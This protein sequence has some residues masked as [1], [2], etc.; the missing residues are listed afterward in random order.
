MG[1]AQPWLREIY[2]V[3]PCINIPVLS[4]P[5]YTILQGHQDSRSR[6]GPTD[7]PHIPEPACGTS[8]V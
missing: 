5:H 8:P 6:S 1:K 3:M 4:V 7:W 2:I